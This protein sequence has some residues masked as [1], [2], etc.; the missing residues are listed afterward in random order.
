MEISY[1]SNIPI[2]NNRP[3]CS[4]LDGVTA[5]MMF[6]YNLEVNFIAI[7]GR[8]QVEQDISLV[9]L[10]SPKPLTQLSPEFVSDML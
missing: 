7:L 4:T 10:L 3:G 9:A 6:Y 5:I 2:G 1:N 8:R